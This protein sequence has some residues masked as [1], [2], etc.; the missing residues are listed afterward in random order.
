MNQVIMSEPRR[1]FKHT[2]KYALRVALAVVFFAPTISACTSSSTNTK[3]PASVASVEKMRPIIIASADFE[4][5]IIGKPSS[6]LPVTAESADK[7]TVTITDTS[8]IIVLNDAI[9]EIVIS[10]GFL[11]NI[12]GRD[13]TTTL[14]ILKPIPKVSSGHDVSAESVLALNP[15]LVIG[16]TRSGPPEAIQQLRGAGVSIL[17]A[18]EVWQ[19]KEIAPRITLIAKALGVDDSGKKLLDET[20]LKIDQALSQATAKKINPRVAFLYVRGTASVFLLGG[21]GSG[22]DEMIQ[23]AGGIDVGTDLGLASFTPLTT[24]AIVKANPDIIIVL[25]LGLK[26]VGGIDGLL[27]LPGIA[28]TP[29]AKTRA[30]ISIDDDLLFSFGPRTGSL[31]VKLAQSFDTLMTA[32]N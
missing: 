26:S 4:L 25:S 32:T 19:L 30:V 3:T 24:E 7:K 28:Q 2:T 29:A 11:K 14:E 8:R 9:A 18:P 22:A 6:K 5:P 15:T 20:Q 27:A 10:L 13:A 12:I 1:N 17:L 16:D 21:E 23:S 31:I